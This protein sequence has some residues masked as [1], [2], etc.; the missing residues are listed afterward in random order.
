M[1]NVLHLIAF[2]IVSPLVYGQSGAE[3][4]LSW[5]DG[6]GTHTVWGAGTVQA[7]YR[8]AKVKCGGKMVA[9]VP[10][11]DT[12]SYEGPPKENQTREYAER[13]NK[14]LLKQFEKNGVMCSFTTGAKGGA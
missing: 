14:S 2:L 11:Y 6:W 9:V 4:F 10:I 7:S 13:M 8:D 12:H 5:Y 3:Q 1:K